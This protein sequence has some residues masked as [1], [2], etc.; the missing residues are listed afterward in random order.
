MSPLFFPQSAGHCRL[1]ILVL[2]PRSRF[3]PPHANPSVTRSTALCPSPFEPPLIFLTGI[4]SPLF[5]H[6]YIWQAKEERSSGLLLLSQ[7][8]RSLLFFCS[9]ATPFPGSGDPDFPAQD[10]VRQILGDQ[11]RASPDCGEASAAFSLFRDRLF[12]VSLR[13]AKCKSP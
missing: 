1:R 13:G 4:S 12:F 9:I 8:E 11:A 3:V 5:S 10:A 6:R 2:A 7:D